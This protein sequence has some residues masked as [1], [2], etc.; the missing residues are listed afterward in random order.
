MSCIRQAV[1]IETLV[2]VV[3]PAY[4]CTKLC[5]VKSLDIATITKVTNKINV[6]SY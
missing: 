1:Q 5:Q 4:I 6:F 2:D 3:P